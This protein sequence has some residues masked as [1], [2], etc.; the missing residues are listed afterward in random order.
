M[1]EVDSRLI[2]NGQVMCPK[3]LKN[4]ANTHPIYGVLPCDKCNAGR[5]SYRST[6]PHTPEYIRQQQRE[7]GAD[8][9]QPH[10]VKN[11]KLRVNEEFVKHYP[12]RAHMY[13]TNEEMK[14]AGMP[15]LI[16]HSQNVKHRE[17]QEKQRIETYKQK[18]IEQSGG[19]QNAMQ[20]ILNRER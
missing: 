8:F 5:D 7:H 17:A 16:E 2:K 12:D 20:R 1:M 13:Y 18:L 11:G 10:V 14:Q 4:P 15:K 3:C 9:V 19:P 6:G